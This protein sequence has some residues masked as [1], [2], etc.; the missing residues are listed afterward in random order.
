MKTLRKNLNAINIKNHRKQYIQKLHTLKNSLQGK[1]ALIITC[2][3][4]LKNY[5]QQHFQQ[6]RDNGYIIV[7]VKQAIKVV[8]EC[9]FHCVNFCNEEKYQYH[10]M[11]N[12]PISLFC[13][14][15]DHKFGKAGIN[16][17]DIMVTHQ[18]NKFKHS[19]PKSIE[20]GID[21]ISFDF[22]LKDKELRVWWGNIM[23]ELALPL[24][25][26]LGIKDIY[27]IGWDCTSYLDHFYSE[28]KP[29]TRTS[30][31]NWRELDQSLI[32]VSPHTAPFLKKQFGITLKNIGNDSAL[33]IPTV[34]IKDLF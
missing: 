15:I 16:P 10:I 6:F 19:I 8:G 22:L 11:K 5:T 24:C 9:H 28:R 4:S 30:K 1:K 13:K 26:H 7:C 17:Y 14:Y 33:K 27:I 3:P 12:K 31:I 29:D 18:S 2:G 20:Q 34:N 25:I 32:D 23:Y 21:R